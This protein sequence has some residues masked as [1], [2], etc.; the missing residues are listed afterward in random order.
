MSYFGKSKFLTRV[1]LLMMA[2]LMVIAMV[3]AG[4]AATSGDVLAVGSDT[5]EGTRN[6]GPVT[7]SLAGGY[8]V[9]AYYVGSG[10]PNLVVAISV[11][12]DPTTTG[13]PG[14]VISGDAPATVTFASPLPAADS[15]ATN[16]KIKMTISG[17]TTGSPIVINDI[18]A[19]DSFG[20]LKTPAAITRLTITPK[21][22]T[23]AFTPPS[24]NYTVGDTVA[25]STNMKLVPDSASG[26][27][28]LVF[29]TTVNMGTKELALPSGAG[30]KLWSDGQLAVYKKS[31][32]MGIIVSPDA[33]LTTV[34]SQS[35]FNI[36][37]NTLTATVGT[38]S[39][40]VV[41]M[42]ATPTLATFTAKVDAANLTLTPNSRTFVVGTAP[43]STSNISAGVTPSTYGGPTSLVIMDG[44]AKTTLTYKGL[45]ITASSADERITFGGNPTGTETGK[46]YEVRWYKDPTNY[47]S[48]DLKIVINATAATPILTLTPASP[49]YYT[50][51]TTHS[52]IIAQVKTGTTAVRITDLKIA[53]SSTATSGDAVLFHGLNFTKSVTSA[54]SPDAYITVEKAS[55]ETVTAGTATFRVYATAGGTVL[56]KDLPITISSGTSSNIT[57]DPTS[58]T[59][60]YND[61]AEKKL[62]ITATTSSLAPTVT[63]ANTSVLTVGTV[64]AKGG[65]VY[66]VTVK[67]A[68]GFTFG[69]S[70]TSTSLTVAI[71]TGSAN[72][73]TVPV[74]LKGSGA[75]GTMPVWSPLTAAH[76]AAIANVAGISS[77]NITTMAAGGAST[78]MPP[79]P[80]YDN[81]INRG[82]VAA[83]LALTQSVTPGGVSGLYF[84]GSRIATLNPNGVGTNVAQRLHV[85]ANTADFR[86]YYDIVKVFGS[87]TNSVSVSLSN[88]IPEFFSYDAANRSV[89]ANGV[90]A[91]ID[92]PAPPTALPGVNIV[93]AGENKQYGIVYSR[94][95][96]GTAYIVICDGTTDGVAKDPIMLVQNYRGGSSGGGCAAGFGAFALVALGGI[97][98]LRRRND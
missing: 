42:L 32:N 46:T 34:K 18:G 11:D 2:V 60:A 93:Y 3:S 51:D 41:A 29:G 20:A 71:G 84:N 70:D 88:L 97:A 64:E 10:T 87:T 66:E 75:T 63:A 62:T 67:P 68:T 82:N 69:A 54:T 92:S 72:T 95:Y 5:T 14:D 19:Y 27:T 36:T 56:S 26:V 23:P 8:T 90:I 83:F 91:I 50:S 12:I 37:A 16:G 89:I 48:A 43:T 13:S 45:T 52:S 59:F 78:T 96:G 47:V 86:N 17:W 6:N 15:S 53:G 81:E 65:G 4:W 24:A 22:I 76:I 39:G 74:T 80:A 28:S 21:P 31:D 57:V 40:I 9:D 94:N 73:K 77:A 61:Y 33:A 58:M 44:T 55:G 98:L 7:G 35:S 79:S 49:T 85:P 25:T 38:D 1:L 30:V